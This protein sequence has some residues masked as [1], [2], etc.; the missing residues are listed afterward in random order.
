MFSELLDQLRGVGSDI[1]QDV[2]SEQQRMKSELRRTVTDVK[3][4]PRTRTITV[5]KPY[6]C[7]ARSIITKALQPYG[8]KIHGISERTEKAEL[9]GFL[10][11]MKV[12]ARTWDN[13]KFGPGAVI[14]LPM[15][16]V[17]E[18]TVNEAAAGWAEYLLLRTGKLYVPGRY[19]NAKN[20]AW[21]ERHGGQMPPAWNE[22]KPWIETSCK[23][24]MDAWHP[25]RDAVKKGRKE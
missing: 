22:K 13:L 4:G 21:A 6:C 14:W 1:A 15:A 11:R 16:I 20:A 9:R 25:I 8:V 10:R 18:V 3:P 24:G 17:A 23:Q 12:E 19:V 2:R 5:A 7:P